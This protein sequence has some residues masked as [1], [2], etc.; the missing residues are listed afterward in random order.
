MNVDPEQPIALLLQLNYHVADIM[1]QF[2]MAKQD[3]IYLFFANN[4]NISDLV[5]V[6]EIPAMRIRLVVGD[7]LMELLS[8]SPIL[9]KVLSKIHGYSENKFCNLPLSK[10]RSIAELTSMEHLL[11]MTGEIPD[12]IG[13]QVRMLVGQALRTCDPQVPADLSQKILEKLFDND[14][15]TTPL[16]PG[17]DHISI[18]KSLQDAG[19]NWF[20]KAFRRQF[21]CIKKGIQSGSNWDIVNSIPKHNDKPIATIF[22]SGH[23]DQH[24]INGIEQ[25]KKLTSKFDLYMDIDTGCTSIRHKNGDVFTYEGKIPHLGCKS[26]SLL[27]T[28]L[29]QPGDFV[30]AYPHK[31]MGINSVL[32]ANSLSMRL[33][34]LRNCFGEDSKNPWF[35]L[36]K[37]SHA[38]TFN[39]NRSFC[40]VSSGYSIDHSHETASS[41]TVPLLWREYFN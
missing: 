41:Q 26:M 3:I 4:L 35:F 8:N 15:D 11:A 10:I 36:Q 14:R 27:F 12:P 5:F 33:A 37:D 9:H 19:V 34:N 22:S 18:V 31:D 30:Y 20:D 28:L 23:F 16:I 29:S 17:T 39:V 40:I 6:F 1:K 32:T 24:T 7:F 21:L 25:K 38:M 2:S 13:T